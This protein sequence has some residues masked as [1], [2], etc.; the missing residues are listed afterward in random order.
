MVSKAASKI[1]L[2]KV[3]LLCLQRGAGGELAVLPFVETRFIA[4][5]RDGAAPHREDAR[6]RRKKKFS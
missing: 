2:R 1:Y 6:E 4:S 3:T 5:V